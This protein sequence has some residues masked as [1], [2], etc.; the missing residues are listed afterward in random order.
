MPRAGSR[1]APGAM[2]AAVCRLGRCRAGVCAF[3][4]PEQI[5]RLPPSCV[6][7]GSGRTFH[8]RLRRKRAKATGILSRNQNLSRPFD[9][10]DRRATKRR[11]SC[12]SRSLSSQVRTGLYAQ[13]PPHIKQALACRLSIR[14]ISDYV[15]LC[16]PVYLNDV[17]R[18]ETY[19]L[20]VQLCKRK[21]FHIRTLFCC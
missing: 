4:R 18:F 3:I 8:S 7:D 11:N 5:A 2:Y 1:R 13:S 9:K 10:N 12:R 19:A 21:R 17:T 20:G 16:L 15:T 6:A 14:L